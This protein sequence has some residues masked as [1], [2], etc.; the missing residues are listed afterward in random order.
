MA[1]RQRHGPA[2]AGPGSHRRCDARAVG[3]RSAGYRMETG[4]DAGCDPASR[5]VP[6]GPP[7]VLLPTAGVELT[8]AAC[9]CSTGGR[10][11]VFAHEGVQLCRRGLGDGHVPPAGP[12]CAPRGDAM[13]RGSERPCGGS[14][15]ESPGRGQWP[16]SG[17]LT[18]PPGG[19]LWARSHGDVYRRGGRRLGRVA[20]TCAR[21]RAG[22]W[23]PRWPSAPPTATSAAAA[24]SGRQPLHGHQ[25]V[26]PPGRR[27]SGPPRR[28]PPCHSS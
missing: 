17:A 15:R 12:Y 18:L 6:L 24:G 22:R 1:C 27:S 13:G 8:H 4:Y 19:Q 3:Q 26:V 9:G 2:S 16:W 28:R 21:C 7:D 10:G 20:C 14:G 11:T 25:G 23:R 5:A